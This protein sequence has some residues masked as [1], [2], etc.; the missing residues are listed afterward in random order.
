MILNESLLLR[1]NDS[2]Q[3]IQD[4]SDSPTEELAPSTIKL[5]AWDIF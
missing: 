5:Y 3:F 2:P 4:D 1:M